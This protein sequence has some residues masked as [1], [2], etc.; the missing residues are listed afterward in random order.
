METVTVVLLDVL[1]V[2][3]IGVFVLLIAAALRGK[4]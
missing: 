3:M 2:C 4:G 1:L